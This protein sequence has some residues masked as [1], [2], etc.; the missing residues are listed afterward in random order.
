MVSLSI[1]AVM[2]CAVD[3]G[4][5]FDKAAVLSDTIKGTAVYSV[6][7]QSIHMKFMIFLP[8]II[9]QLFWR[10]RVYVNG[11]AVT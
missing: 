11:V 1:S 5:L 10:C 4:L 9:G 8:T 2:G 7:F 6:T 3:A